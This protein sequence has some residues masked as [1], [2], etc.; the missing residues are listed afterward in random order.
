L[1]SNKVISPV[2]TT[3]APATKP[4]PKPTTTQSSSSRA[5][6][7]EIQRLSNGRWLLDSVADDKDVAIAMAQAL[8]GS[9]RAPAEVRVSA[10]KIQLDGTF[11][12]VSVFH[13]TAEEKRASKTKSDAPAAPAP[14]GKGARSA[15]QPAA[16][17]FDL[18]V[19]KASFASLGPRAWLLAGGFIFAWCAIFYV[20]HRPQTPWAFDS[21]AAQTVVKSHVTMP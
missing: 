6:N 8:L 5:R 14:R 12:E 11:S 17:S 16:K 19:V 1:P 18:A 15:A 21:P 4:A 3:A 2:S 9:N 10:V 7:Y 20:W 13:A